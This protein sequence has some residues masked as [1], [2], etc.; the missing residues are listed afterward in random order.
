[1]KKPLS[2]AAQ[3]RQAK[4]EARLREENKLL[5]S[6]R[7][8][9]GVEEPRKA[10]T[11]VVNPKDTEIALNVQ[12]GMTVYNATVAAGIKYKSRDK[13]ILH[14]E[15]AVKRYNAM[16]IESMGKQG[17]TPDRVASKL[18][19]LLDAEKPVVT[20]DGVIFVSDHSAQQRAVDTVLDIL[21][22][23]RAPKQVQVE[24]RSLEQIIMKIQTDND[25]DEW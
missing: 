18:N 7:S 19:S 25:G 13:T 23:A 5:I 16:M 20:K 9:R 12:N 8:L 24:T 11:T 21:P 17:I 3:K 4:V 1:M 22:G 6:S 10:M 2:K 14:G 15:T